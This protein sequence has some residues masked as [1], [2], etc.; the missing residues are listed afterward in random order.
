ME[1]NPSLDAARE[2]RQRIL[3]RLEEEEETELADLLRKCGQPLNLVCTNCGHTHFTETKCK[4]KWCPVCV[5]AIATRRSLKFANAARSMTWPLFLTLTVRNVGDSGVPFVRKLRRDFGKLRHRK[6]WKD[7][8]VGGVAAIEVTNKGK[9]WHPHLHALIDC[10]WLAI[11]TPKLQRGMS[12]DARKSRLRQAKREFTELWKR[13][14]KEK[15]GVCWVQRCSGEDTAREVLKYSVKGEH[16]AES[17]DRIGPLIHQLRATRLVTSFGTL[18]GKQ[19]V[20]ADADKPPLVCDACKKPTEWIPD[21]LMTQ[22]LKLRKK[23]A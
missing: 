10:E 21:F 11:R 9:G 8:V 14:A 15:H 7:N 12:R 22:F 5:R 1:S 18:F 20:P 16:L 13:V 17:A 2:Y 4:Q 19:L 23:A 6:I 3:A